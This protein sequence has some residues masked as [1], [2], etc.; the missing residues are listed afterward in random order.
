MNEEIWTM[1]DGTKIAVGDM[2]ESHVR[3]ALRMIIRS[4]RKKAKC[5]SAALEETLTVGEMQDLL[6]HQAYAALSNTHAF[7][8]LLEGGKHGS[9]DLADRYDPRRR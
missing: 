4:A 1:R 7:F 9:P 3:N 5:A 6:S 8:P 2:A